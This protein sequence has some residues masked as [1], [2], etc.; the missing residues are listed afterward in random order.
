MSYEASTGEWLL[1]ILLSRLSGRFR[2]P[3]S[4]SSF[5]SA[6]TAQPKRVALLILGT[7]RCLFIRHVFR[8]STRNTTMFI[9]K[10]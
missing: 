4:T 2:F 1:V 10:P 3:P 5:D 6:P 7:A 9:E 8:D